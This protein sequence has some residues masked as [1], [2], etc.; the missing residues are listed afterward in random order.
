MALHCNGDVQGGIVL[1]AP[2]AGLLFVEQSP[3]VAFIRCRPKRVAEISDLSIDID[4]FS[5][6]QMTDCLC[7]HLDRLEGSQDWESRTF[8]IW[9]STARGGYD[10]E[11][12]LDTQCFNRMSLLQGQCR[13]CYHCLQNRG[14]GLLSHSSTE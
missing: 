12:K 13:C 5:R 8:Q 3:A 4:A 14:T 11:S 2:D 9:A 10:D 1:D 6:D 7:K